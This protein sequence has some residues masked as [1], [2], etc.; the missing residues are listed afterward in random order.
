VNIEYVIN[1]Y[2]NIAY[3]SKINRNDLTDL[4]SEF[5]YH[6]KIYRRVLQSIYT[7]L[8]IRCPLETITSSESI[9]ISM[10]IGAKERW[11]NT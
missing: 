5:K 9:A 1:D 7:F 3:P 2:L 6:R 4:V 10:P 11:F 8:A